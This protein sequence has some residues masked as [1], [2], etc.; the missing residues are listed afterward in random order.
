VRHYLKK[1]GGA[2]SITDTLSLLIFKHLGSVIGASFVNFFLFVP[3]IIADL[4]RF[5]DKAK[6][7]SCDLGCV[8][9][10]DLVRSDAMAYVVLTGNSYCNS[11]KY[12]EYF[13]RESMTCDSTQSPLRLYRISA[14]I[15]IAGIVS[16]VGLYI[17]GQIEPYTIA[18]TIIIGMFVSTYIISYQADP[19]EAILLMFNIDQEY[20][21]RQKV[22]LALS[23]NDE[24]QQKTL[25]DWLSK[26]VS[27]REENSTLA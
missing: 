18:A 15:L 27:K 16:L 11:A 12:C 10:L 17:K 7:D 25:L 21:R 6:T 5:T 2:C 3:D 23:L 20:F 8:G 9:F 19:A 1:G 24:T 22:K 13:T 26:E 4:F 14:H